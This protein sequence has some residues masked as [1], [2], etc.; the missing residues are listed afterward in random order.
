MKF[1]DNEKYPDEIKTIISESIREE[2]NKKLSILGLYVGDNVIVQGE[3]GG[4]LS[5]FSILTILRNGNGNI[6]LKITLYDP[7]KNI[8]HQSLINVEFQPGQNAILP[9]QLSPFPIKKFGDFVFEIIFDDNEDIKY[10][11]KFNI[12]GTD[13]PLA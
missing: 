10:E 8:I 3:A 2:V 7:D 13:K 1:S 6:H 9:I 4:A 5:S 12:N 11:Y